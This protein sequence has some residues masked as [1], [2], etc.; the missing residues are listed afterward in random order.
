MDKTLFRP[1]DSTTWRMVGPAD[2]GKYTLTD[3]LITA[4]VSRAVLEESWTARVGIVGRYAV[5]PTLRSYMLDMRILSGEVALDD[6]CEHCPHTGEERLANCTV[7]GYDMDGHP[8]E[9]RCCDTCTVNV[10]DIVNDTDP[11]R[12]VVVERMIG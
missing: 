12:V 1:W 9:T 5:T 7:Y 11:S 8:L 6:W 10:I 3:G 4:D 2:G